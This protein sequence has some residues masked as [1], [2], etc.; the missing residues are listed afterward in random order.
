MF[1]FLQKWIGE[2]VSY[3]INKRQGS[4]LMEKDDYKN[5]VME[6]E[7]MAG[8]MKVHDPD[9]S[10]FE[11]YWVFNEALHGCPRGIKAPGGYTVFKKKMSDQL[12]RWSSQAVRTNQCLLS[13]LFY[14][15]T[16]SN[17]TH[18]HH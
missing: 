7:C 18:T 6:N 8:F 15:Q 16:I 2:T 4:F 1:T 9:G 10:M 17:T 11:S 5:L 14:Y 12:G 13:I 3:L